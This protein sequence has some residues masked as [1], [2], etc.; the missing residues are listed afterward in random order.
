MA[1]PFYI[2]LVDESNESDNVVFDDDNDSDA[3]S[4]TLDNDPDRLYFLRED[5][6][7]AT[8]FSSVPAREIV[9]L[10]DAE[11]FHDGDYLTDECYEILREDWARSAAAAKS[12]VHAEGVEK[13]CLTE[14]CVDGIVYMPGQSVE[15]HDDS[16][17]R[18]CSVWEEPDGQISFQGRRL[19]LLETIDTKDH[20]GIYLPRWPN[21][22]VWIVG[23][24]GAVPLD[25]V[26]RFVPLF[27]TNNCHASQDL[28]KKSRS[29]DLFCRLKEDLRTSVEYLAFEE[30]DTGYQIKPETL[31]RDWRGNTASFGSEMGAPVIV[32]DDIEDDQSDPMAEERSRRK[33]TFGDG[34][35]GAGG[36]SCGAETAGL[37]IKWAFDLSPHAA[38]TYRLNFATAECEESDIFSFLTNDERFMRVDI[39]HGSPPCQTFSPAHTI[40]CAND[41]ANSACIFSCG[42]LIRR[43]KPRIHTMEE[44]S[45]L[46]E[47]HKETFFGVIHDFIET[48]YSVRWA[49]LN[50]MEYGVPQSR[51]RLVIIASGPGELLPSM[52]KPTHGLPGSGLRDLTTINQMISN[53]PPGTPDH[54]VESAR[55]RGAS[56]WRAPFDANQQA[57]T[58]TCSGGENNYHPSGQRGFTNRE[59]ACLQTFPLSF[60]FGPRQ[61]RKQIGNAVPPLLANAIYREIIRT[62]QDTDERE[63]REIGD[64]Q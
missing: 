38:G 41:D 3:S 14:V 52:P 30:S 47:R 40:A 61:V 27:F 28:H 42:D 56:T 31:R 21:E 39:T 36:V 17:L 10:T 6:R 4:V 12:P 53:I 59:F 35:C 58:I 20:D 19:W 64:C 48:G 43:A 46:F 62:L 57:R 63:L 7:T 9:D 45:G 34:F 49:L 51:K 55:I 22:L 60:R 5:S 15:L 23:E 8:P 1:H 32:L 44:T 37:Y 50:C 26:R 13:K 16:F 18:I 25:I 11:G 33:Y 54:D 29:K 24:T 2:D